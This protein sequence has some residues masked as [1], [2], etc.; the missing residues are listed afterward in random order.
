M[1]VTADNIKKFI[2]VEKNLEP[3]KIEADTLL[4]S[5]G[6]LDSF[7]MI[8]LVSFLEKETGTRVKPTE[9]TLENFDSISRMLSFLEGR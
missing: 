6:L 8:E 3:E 1:A 7:S 4:F 2:V 9:V 5:S